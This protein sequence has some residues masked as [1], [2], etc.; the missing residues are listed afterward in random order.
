MG[1]RNPAALVMG[2]PRLLA[3]ASRVR[4]ALFRA[5]RLCPNLRDCHLA[6]GA[7]PPRPLP[8]PADVAVARREVCTSLGLDPS[9][10]E[11]HHPA[12][13]PRDLPGHGPRRR[14]PRRPRAGLVTRW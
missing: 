7:S 9:E 10:G 11:L 4:D 2:Q 8:L 13:A 6:C 3:A 12:A 14:R 5:F 1:A